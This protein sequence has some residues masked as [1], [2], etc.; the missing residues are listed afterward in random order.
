MKDSNMEKDEMKKAGRPAK[1]KSPDEMVFKI[2]EYFN[3]QCKNVPMLDDDGNVLVTKTGKPLIEYNPPTL[4][5]L[6]LYLGFADRKS[7]HDY[8]K[9]E[10]FAFVIRQ[11]I[12]RMEEYAEKQLTTGQTSGAMFWLKNQGW[13][14]KE[15]TENTNENNKSLQELGISKKDIIALAKQYQT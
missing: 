6:A 12:A 9:K 7:L 8:K 4:A 15:P 14:E 2:D 11:A 13:S 10:K 3:T 1:Y 5:G